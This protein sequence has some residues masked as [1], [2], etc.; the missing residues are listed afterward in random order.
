SGTATVSCTRSDALAASSSY[1]AITLTVNVGGG[2]PSVINSATLTG[3]G[4]FPRSTTDV[5]RINASTLAITKTHTGDFT[6]GQNGTYTIGVSNVGTTATAGTVTM[7]DV[8]PSS[9]S[10]AS[11][12]GTGWNCSGVS[13]ITCTRSDALAAGS[14]Y[15][16]ITLAVSVGGNVGAS[17]V[18]N[19]ATVTGGGDGVILSASDPTNVNAATLEITKSHNGTFTAGQ[20]GSYL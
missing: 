13:T 19:T 8:L 12:G 11:V 10:A 14:S 6:V 20:S 1:P 5:T 16:P 3:G 4:D 7:T 17:L 2:G 9:M 15:P 18:T